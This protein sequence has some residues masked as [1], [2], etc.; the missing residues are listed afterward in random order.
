M[1]G[2]QVVSSL[3]ELDFRWTEPYETQNNIFSRNMNIN[4]LLNV[5]A[6]E[7]SQR[8]HNQRNS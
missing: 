6:G 1:Q 4:N 7:G 2:M 3:I 8:G 5:L